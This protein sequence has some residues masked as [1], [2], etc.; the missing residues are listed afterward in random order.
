MKCPTCSGT[1]KIRGF[2]CPG[3]VPIEIDCVAC[4]GTGTRPD[5]Q[6]QWIEEGKAMKENRIARNLS[7]REEAARRKMNPAELSEMERGLRKPVPAD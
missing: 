1:G 2:G 6:A 5:E 7:L 3:F 4:T